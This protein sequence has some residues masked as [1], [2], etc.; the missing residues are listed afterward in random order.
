MMWQG[1]AWPDHWVR[2]WPKPDWTAEGLWPV[3]FKMRGGWAD[4][5]WRW[6]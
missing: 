1:E 3:A 4:W 5:Y 2:S 6:A